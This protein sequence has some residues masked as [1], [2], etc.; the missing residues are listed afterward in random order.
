MALF[1]SSRTAKAEW[2]RVPASE[3]CTGTHLPHA[4][5]LVVGAESNVPFT[6]CDSENLPVAHSIPSATDRRSFTATFSGTSS[7]LTYLGEGTYEVA[8]LAELH[9]TDVLQVN[10][11]GDAAVPPL[12]IEAA[13]PST[14][15]T[16]TL[17]TGAEGVASSHP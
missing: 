4:P 3:A 5:R 16:A 7:P 14:G 13:C 10:I 2:G 9:G 1:V 17:P 6:A 11:D 8:V 15:R 12:D